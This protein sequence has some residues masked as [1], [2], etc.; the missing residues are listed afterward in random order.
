MPR[1][2]RP[3]RPYLA[4][5]GTALSIVLASESSAQEVT[6]QSPARDATR[7][8]ETVTVEAP[9]LKELKRQI[10]HFVSN[11]AVSYLND[12]LERWDTPVCPL[13]ASLTKDDGEFVLA[14]ISKIARTSHAPL[15][16]EHC[17]ANLYIIVTVNPGLYVRRWVKRD[18]F[19]LSA[20]N[21]VGYI[22]DFLRARGPVRV[23]Y[24]AE[25]RSAGAAK[26]PLEATGL[27]F[28]S[29]ALG[30]GLS[31][32]AAAGGKVDTRISYGVVQA[33]TSVIIVVDSERTANINI[34]QLADYVA[35]IG[36]AQIHLNANTGT[37][38]TILSLFRQTDRAP[39]GLSPWDESFL[40]SLYTTNQNSVLQVSAIKAGMLEQIAH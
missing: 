12:S 24:N 23:Y 13:V 1:W 19:L 29:V 31:P 16:S 6:S 30:P 25:F 33:L 28:Q 32:C 4:L 22:D 39:Q 34:G 17:R 7:N 21:G 35:L 38:P 15:G 20:C 37:A 18:P 10:S 11:L 3:V 5:A 2:V 8:V 27:A 9:R 14:R 36:L 26:V 40:H